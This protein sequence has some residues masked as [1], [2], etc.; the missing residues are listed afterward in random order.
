[1]EDYTAIYL[2]ASQALANGESQQAFQ[3]LRWLLHYPGHSE[4]Y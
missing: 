2:E 3:R 1:M 4:L